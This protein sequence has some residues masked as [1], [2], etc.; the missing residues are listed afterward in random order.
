MI[1]KTGLTLL[2]FVFQYGLNVCEGT[3]PISWECADTV[4]GVAPGFGITCTA[5][6]LLCSG[7]TPCADYKVRYK[8]AAHRGR[9]TV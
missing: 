8:C 6:G 3:M 5:D 7:A 9:Y 1:F 2:Y 4:T